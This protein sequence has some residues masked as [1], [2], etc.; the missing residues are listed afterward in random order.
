MNFNI[1]HDALPN[2]HTPAEERTP[3]GLAFVKVL[4][5]GFKTLYNR[6]ICAR[7]ETLYKLKFNAQVMYLEKLL[8][9]QFNNGLPSYTGNIPTGIYI[10]KPLNNIKPPVLRRKDELRPRLVLWSKTD[11]AFNPVL[12]KRI[13]M[14]SKAEYITNIKFIVNVPIACFD[15]TTDTQQLIK[16]KGWINYYNDISNYSIVNY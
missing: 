4:L 13:V 8:N 12:H 16:M 14:R 9:E 1:D 2:Q 11:P 5:K 7:A 3:E 6:F 15:V 10:S